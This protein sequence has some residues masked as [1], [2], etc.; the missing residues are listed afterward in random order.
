MS[1]INFRKAIKTSFIVCSVITASCIF[2]CNKKEDA[3]V[4]E[5]EM[6]EIKRVAGF[7]LAKG[8]TIP[9]NIY[10][11]KPVFG[12]EDATILFTT[13]SKL[14]TTGVTSGGCWISDL[15]VSIRRDNTVGDWLG[16]Y[17]KI[18]VDLNEGAGG[19]WIYMFYKKSCSSSSCIT[20]LE[21]SIGKD[22]TARSY[23]AFPNSLWKVVTAY[24]DDSWADLNDGAGG[25]YIY[26]LYRRNPQFNPIRDIMIVSANSSTITYTGWTKIP[27][28]LNRNAHGKL[29]F[30]F[31]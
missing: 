28:D 19:K 12:N 2:S 5:S 26:A 15:T 4:K 31:L 21:V 1:K 8:D 14:K 27:V 13:E 22:Y 10:R 30:Y 9:K 25:D 16:D 24:W 17:Q 7:E 6:G 23:L 3:K 11:E 20:D 18:P 29:Y